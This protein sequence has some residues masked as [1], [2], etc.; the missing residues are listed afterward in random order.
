MSLKYSTWLPT[1]LQAKKKKKKKKKA[2]QA[3]DNFTNEK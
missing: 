1:Y 3:Q 2:F